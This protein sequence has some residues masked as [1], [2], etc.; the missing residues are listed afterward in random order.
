MKYVEKPTDCDQ[1]NIP[2]ISLFELQ[3]K[4]ILHYCSVVS[5]D[6]SNTVNIENIDEAVKNN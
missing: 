6:D 3:S 2:N 1:A 5:K 4:M